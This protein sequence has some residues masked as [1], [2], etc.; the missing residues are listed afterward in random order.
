MS[1]APKTVSGYLM[2]AAG[3]AGSTGG[4]AVGRALEV[5]ANHAPTELCRTEH[6]KD[7][8][9]ALA[10][11]AGRRLVIAGGD[12]SL[13]L[14]VNALLARGEAAS[15]PV[16]VIPLGTGN[17]L[18]QSLGLPLDPAR[19]AGRVVRGRVRALDVLH[20]GEEMAVNAAHAGLGVA[21]ARG[22]QRLKPVLGVLGY[23]V[24]AAWNGAVRDGVEATVAVDGRSVCEGQPVLLVAV[25]NGSSIGGD[26]PLCPSAD[27]ADGLLDVVVVTDRSRAARAAF[28]LALSRGRHLGLPGVTHGQGRHVSVR[29]AE[30]A[31]NVDGEIIATPPP[32]E[33]RAQPGA[34]QIVM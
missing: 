3:N 22:A 5:L 15:T 16:G 33:W 4:Q 7:L 6:P 1:P 2:L 24:A 31:W 11:L 12:G 18:A 8:E 10:A 34:W 19:A 30:G 26:T 20:G 32:S 13:H 14:V 25:M 17:D 29:I 23:R 28:A 9:A 21:A 27:P